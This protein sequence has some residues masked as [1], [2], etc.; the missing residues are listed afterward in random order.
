M[1]KDQVVND[2]SIG[3]CTKREEYLVRSKRS[4]FLC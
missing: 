3:L 4:T 2:H 1:T